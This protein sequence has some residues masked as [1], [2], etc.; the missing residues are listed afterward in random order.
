MASAPPRRGTTLV[1]ACLD[2][3]VRLGKP[4]RILSPKADL[5]RSVG[6][7]ATRLWRDDAEGLSWGREARRR[8]YWRIWGDASAAGG[9]QLAPFHDGFWSICTPDAHTIVQDT[10]VM[11]DNAI[12][13][14]LALDKGLT[15]RLLGEAGIPV[16][17][18]VEVS[19]DDPGAALE[20]ITGVGGPC[21]VKPANGT[22]GGDGVT[23]GVDA[24]E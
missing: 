21:V 19:A 9:G 10:N 6:P 5:L 20:F 22:A 4:G 23:C 14:R 12:R 2:R 7:L 3:T 18:N 16:A 15:Q 24:E 17:A 13:H 1:T 8:L 11:L